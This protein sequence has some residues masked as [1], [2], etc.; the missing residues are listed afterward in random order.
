MAEGVAGLIRD[1]P[2]GPGKPPLP[3]AAVQRVIDL[4]LGPPPGSAPRWTSRMLANAAGVSL[5][6]VQRIVEAHQLA[7][8]GSRKF[9]LLN[10]PTFSGRLEYIAGF[11]VD[12]PAHAVVLSLGD[13]TPIRRGLQMKPARAGTT[14]R[15]YRPRGFSTLFAA[16]DVLDSNAIRRTAIRPRPQAFIGFLEELEA[17]IPGRKAICAVVDHE[18]TH[19]H[20]KVCEW[21]GQHP[22]WTVHFAPVSISWRGA[23]QELLANPARGR[24][25]RG[26]F[27]SIAELRYALDRFVSQVEGSPTPFVWTAEPS[28][29]V[30]AKKKAR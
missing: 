18:A 10:D 9:K 13:Q 3:R 21:L 7:P 4:A 15:D 2:R 20:P 6:S 17:Q 26:V 29:I 25:K 1:K 8:Y 28:R 27:R 30:S 16:L 22:R 24:L 14:T 11:Y 5:G 19:K 12:P 23:V